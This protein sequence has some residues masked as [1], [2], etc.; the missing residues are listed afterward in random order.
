MCQDTVLMV[1]P[2]RNLSLQAQ[3][4]FIL[5]TLASWVAEMHHH[6]LASPTAHAHLQRSVGR[7]TLHFLE[8]HP[9]ASWLFLRNSSSHLTPNSRV[10]QIALSVC[11]VLMRAATWAAG[12]PGMTEVP[13]RCFSEV[14]LLCLP[15]SQHPAHFLEISQV[16]GNL[17][18]GCILSSF[19]VNDNPSFK[20]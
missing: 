7:H 15:I 12:H 3:H 6:L 19:L 2:I 8:L 10:H 9:T 14:S 20:Q 11:W 5:L 13:L 18:R 16:S 17:V 4:F 1:A